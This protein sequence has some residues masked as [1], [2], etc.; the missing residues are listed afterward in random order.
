MPTRKTTLKKA[1]RTSPNFS[2]KKAGR[3]RPNVFDWLGLVEGPACTRKIALKKTDLDF[4]YFLTKK[5]V[6][7]GQASP[8]Y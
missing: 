7:H 5:R 3:K 1:G 6:E 4:P 8:E 2:T